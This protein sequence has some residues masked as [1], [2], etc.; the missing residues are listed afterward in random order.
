[1]DLA[2]ILVTLVIIYQ[3][4]CDILKQLQKNDSHQK[5]NT[6]HCDESER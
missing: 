4:L 1:M 6:D 5:T 3:K 2:I